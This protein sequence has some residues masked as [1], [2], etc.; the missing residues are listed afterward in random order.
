MHLVVLN[1]LQFKSVPVNTYRACL[2]SL[3]M[4]LREAMQGAALT[5]HQLIVLRMQEAVGRL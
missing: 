2:K 1:K 3:L 5:L 4:L